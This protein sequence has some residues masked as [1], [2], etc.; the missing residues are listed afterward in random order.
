MDAEKSPMKA[1]K[2]PP[3]TKLMAALKAH[4]SDAFCTSSSSRGW[5]RAGPLHCGTKRLGS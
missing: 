1:P 4:D 3:T 5:T 2:A